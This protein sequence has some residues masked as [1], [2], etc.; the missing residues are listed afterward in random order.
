MI[1]RFLVRDGKIDLRS[2]VGRLEYERAYEFANCP[3]IFAEL[4]EHRAQRAVPF[5][6]VWRQ[7]DDF[8]ELLPGR[9]NV[10]PLFRGVARTKGCIG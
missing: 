9:G 5:G 10:P 8:L 4:H 7:Q 6:Y 3:F 2:A 1:T